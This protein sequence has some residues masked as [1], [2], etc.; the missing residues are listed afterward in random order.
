M[1]SISEEA[2]VSLQTS[3]EKKSSIF[4]ISL[5]LLASY[6]FALLLSTVAHEL[7]HGIAMASMSIDF[8]LVF[9][10]FGTSMAMPSNPIP[11]NV[12]A[13][14]ASAGTIVELVVGTLVFATL[15]RWRTQRL[16]PLLMV[17]PIS[18]L[19]SG[20]YFLVGVSI[21][22]GDTALM[23]ALGVPSPLIQILGILMTIVGVIMLTLMF[24]LLGLS[25]N[26]SFQRVL[27]VLF[28]GF[29]L[30]GFGMIVFAMIFNPLEVY[31]GIANVISMTVTVTILTV[32]FTRGG[33][34]LE[35]ISKSEVVV[36][37]RFNVL[38]TAGISLVFIIFELILLV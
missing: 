10:P 31:I 12:L 9:N 13:F 22:E 7:G 6:I 21:P 4:E 2:A 33:H 23:I 20:G 30:Y 38:A 37:K 11:L 14:V 34:I 36:L 26:D 15:W 27:L 32:I 1:K 28:V 5:F 19:K 29:V 24:P 35:R 16:I 18:F 3:P 17:A 25:R 8:Q